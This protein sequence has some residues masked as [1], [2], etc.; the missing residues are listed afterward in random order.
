MAKKGSAKEVIPEGRIVG[1]YLV[2]CA[3]C[4]KKHEWEKWD[5]DI[6]MIQR[7]R[8][9]SKLGWQMFHTL[10]YCH[11]CHAKKVQERDKKVKEL[12]ARE[13]RLK[14]ERAQLNEEESY[15]PTIG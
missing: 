7:T 4:G 2:V 1:K 5:D 6:T 15:E 3:G 14:K 8:G 12:A 10:W 13:S 11:D 9:L